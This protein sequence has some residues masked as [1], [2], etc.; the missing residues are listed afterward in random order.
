VARSTAAG[1]LGAL[2]ALAA[3][4]P[5]FVV[6]SFIIVSSYRSGDNA[7]RAAASADIANVAE[8]R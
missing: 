6:S 3:G 2:E 5:S 1:R 7:G 8:V 4:P